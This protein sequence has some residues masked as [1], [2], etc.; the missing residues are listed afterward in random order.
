LDHTA[1]IKHHLIRDPFLRPLVDT[2]FR[3][4][5]DAHG[6]LHLQLMQSIAGQQLH[7]KAAET[8][9]RRFLGLFDNPNPSA[10]EVLALPLSQMRKAGLSESKCH[11]IHQFCELL[12][13]EKIDDHYWLTAEQHQIIEKLCSV[14]GIGLWTA[15]MFLLFAC[16]RSD[17]FSKGDF[18]LKDAVIKLYDLNMHGKELNKEIQ[19]ISDLW[20]PYRSHAALILWAWR[21][22]ELRRA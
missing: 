16:G 8:I 6:S 15:E 3:H 1:L 2:Y 20:S 17:I 9:W 4:L 18:A 12:T 19:S 13:E 10:D 7:V 22:A 11:S 5:T 14:K 21:D